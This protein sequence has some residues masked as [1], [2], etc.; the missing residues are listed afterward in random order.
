MTA[1][2]PAH[3]PDNLVFDF[4]IYA[5][6]A[7]DGDF[8]QAWRTLQ[9]PGIPDVVWTPRNGGHWIPTRA[10]VIAEVMSDHALF[11]NH[12]IIIPKAH[13]E[14]HGLIPTTMDPPEHRPYRQL[15][16]TAL[17]PDRVN[18]VESAI[19]ATATALIDEVAGRGECDFIRD[20]SDRFPI[21]VFMTLMDLP[22]SEA[23]Q[24]KYWC[25][26]LLR[27]DGSMTFA[28]A[29]AQLFD[30]MEPYVRA[31]RDAPGNDLVSELVTGYIGERRIDHE[32]A[33]KLAVQVLIAGLDTVVNFLGFAMH[34]LA[35]HPAQQQALREDPGL[36]NAAVE[37]L[38]RRFAV[39][40]IGREVT[41]DTDFHGAP[42]RE[43]DMVATPS[44]LAGIDDRE[45]PD[46]MTVNFN[47]GQQ[48]HLTFGRGHHLCPGRNLARAEIRITIERWLAVI[49]TFSVP[50]EAVITFQGGIVGVLDALPLRWSS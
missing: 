23:E 35:T 21:R 17:A 38:L 6:P 27:P 33:M 18:A 37:E 44:P 19:E 40:T 5:P 36:I 31:R 2:Q 50:E 25:D 8:Y 47:R 20:Y 14:S 41:R 28:E 30:Y 48:R 10:A 46:A 1:T 4:D 43:G 29:M 42:L 39:V 15:L 16:N 26:Q 7:Q 3:V 11:S 49:P 12:T 32:D 13:G 24:T 22:E 34:Y 9:A 45:T